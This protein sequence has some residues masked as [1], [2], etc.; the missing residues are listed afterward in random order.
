MKHKIWFNWSIF[1]CVIM[2]ITGV[3]YIT[4]GLVNLFGEE[5]GKLE[6]QNFINDNLNTK[7]ITVLSI[8][9]LVG[10]SVITTFL[11]SMS[12]QS[13]KLDKLDEE[14]IKYQNARFRLSKKIN[15]L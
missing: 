6:F 3:V 8:L 10:M 12:K 13:N 4:I 7:F 1:F 9:N 14:I 11:L 2:F 5:V 15:E